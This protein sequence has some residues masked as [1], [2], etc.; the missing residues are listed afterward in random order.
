MK[1]LILTFAITVAL[2]SAT[3]ADVF[4]TVI[5][6]AGDSPL[7][8]TVEDGRVLTVLSFL[9]PSGG[10]AG[11]VM[12]VTKDGK[13]TPAMYPVDILNSAITVNPTNVVVAG[14]ATVNV[15][16]A[17]S[18]LFSYRIDPNTRKFANHDN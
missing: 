3:L 13:S 12:S 5:L 2:A 14:P 11:S 17:T 9:G 16:A 7:T 6:N 1:L 4:S 10:T 18:L 15:T 8:V